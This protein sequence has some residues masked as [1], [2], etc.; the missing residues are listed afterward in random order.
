SSEAAKTFVI[1]TV[2]KPAIES[3][4]VSQK[5]RDITKNQIP[6]VSNFK[7]VGDLYRYLLST[8]K[9]KDKNVYALENAGLSTYEDI[10]S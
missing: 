1:N 10:I 8:T 7:R 2:L 9:T 4:I 3:E 5:V 6:W